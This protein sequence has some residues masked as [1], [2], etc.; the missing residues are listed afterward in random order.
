MV[1]LIGRVDLV[2]IRRVD[3]IVKEGLFDDHELPEIVGIQG[4]VDWI[5]RVDLVVIGRVDMIVKEVS[6]RTMNCR[7]SLV[8]RAWW[9]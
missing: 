3:M 4:L 7:K 1:D 9:T 6:L 2:V 5:G 8:S